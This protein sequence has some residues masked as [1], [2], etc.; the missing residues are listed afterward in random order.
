MIGI[1][2]GLTLGQLAN[3]AMG[4]NGKPPVDL[5]LLAVAV[6]VGIGLVFGLLPARRAARMDPIDAVRYE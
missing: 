3:L 4:V 6:S 2:F 5:T 1:V